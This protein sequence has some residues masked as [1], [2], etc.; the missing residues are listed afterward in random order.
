MYKVFLVEDEIVTRKGIRNTIP[1]REN[2][3]EYA[4]DAP[5]GEKAL[6][7]I[8]ETHPDIVITD[9]R[10]PFMDGLEL[11]RILRKEFPD[12]K[13]I[14]LS[15]HDEF[16]YAQKAIPLEVSSYQLKPVTPEE[17]TGALLEVTAQLDVDRQEKAAHLAL[18]EKSRAYHEL[19][20]E[21][22][23]LRLITGGLEPVETIAQSERLHLNIVAQRYLVMVLVFEPTC[24]PIEVDYENYQ[25]LK[26]LAVS[27]V[28]KNPDVLWFYKDIDELVLL[29]KGMDFSPLET[30]AEFLS[31][32]IQE[33]LPEKSTCRL[34][35]GIG[36]ACSCLADLKESYAAAQ[37]ALENRTKNAGTQPIDTLLFPVLK[38]EDIERMLNL[39]DT[40][41]FDT[42]FSREIRPLQSAIE[43]S[44][45]YRNYVLTHLVFTC[46]HFIR[47]MGGNPFHVLSDL[48]YLENRLSTIKDFLS[49]RNFIQDTVYRTLEFRDQQVH[50]LNNSIIWEAK[51]FLS[52]NYQNPDISLQD[53]TGHVNISTSHFSRIFRREVGM[54]FVEYLTSLRIEQAKVLLCTTSKRAYE[55]AE[56]VGYKDPHYFSTVFKRYAGCSPSEYQDLKLSKNTG[57]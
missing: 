9:I 4:G 41:D 45:V 8:R 16:E 53:V 29:I 2:G 13:I 3:L 6:P 15:G 12:V 25:A 34:R 31:N 33:T 48:D 57:G 7:L 5:D 52:D 32:L 36:T 43:H 38:R 50:N 47:S 20:Q 54:T 44:N 18:L 11:S 49:L 19:L 23:I 27:A 39:E 10:M 46:A 37:Y 1:W 17:L 42:F 14:I 26:R 24:N 22:F 35:I 28:E 40:Q 51:A 56:E 21:K 55:V 30:E